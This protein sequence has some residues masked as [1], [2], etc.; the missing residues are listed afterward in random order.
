MEKPNGTVIK[1]I[2]R[3]LE[4]AF[5]GNR[6]M[7]LK[8]TFTVIRVY[9]R[10][11]FWKWTDY[12][13]MRSIPYISSPFYDG[14]YSTNRRLSAMAEMMEQDAKMAILQDGEAESDKNGR[15]KK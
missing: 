10:F 6:H 4:N 13:I 2:V 7:D 8:V 3:V 1:T 5:V 9:H 12:E 11:L 14:E 15:I